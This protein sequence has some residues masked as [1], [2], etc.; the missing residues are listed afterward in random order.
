M[1]WSLTGMTM[2]S[3]PPLSVDESRCCWYSPA[4][5]RLKQER[6]TSVGRSFWPEEELR[7]TTYERL[8]RSL[9][10]WQRSKWAGDRP[11]PSASHLSS[12]Y[13]EQMKQKGVCC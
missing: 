4:R 2:R 11:L 7:R 6:L 5:L 10:C 9:G 12:R 3:P 8:Q 13:S 1:D